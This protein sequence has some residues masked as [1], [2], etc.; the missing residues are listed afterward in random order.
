MNL[1]ETLGLVTMV[2]ALLPVAIF[3][4]TFA[5]LMLAIVIVGSWV[6]FLRFIGLKSAA[7]YVERKLL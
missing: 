6:Q 7:S 4:V 1:L 2:I 5:A 3:C